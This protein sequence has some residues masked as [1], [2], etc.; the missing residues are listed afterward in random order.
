[1]L[2]AQPS[3]F[4][5]E[6]MASNQQFLLD[7]D[8]DDSDWIELYNATAQSINVLG[9]TLSDKADALNRWALPDTS[10]EPGGF[11]VVFA[12]G[13]DRRVAGQPLH[14]NFSIAAAGE[15]LFL[16]HNGTLVHSLSAR[17]LEQNQSAGLV[18]DGS[19][20]YLRIAN[21]SPGYTNA[22][23]GVAEL[24]TFSHPGGFYEAGFYLSLQSSHPN[25]QIRYTLNGDQPTAQSARYS[26]PLL[27]NETARNP[28]QLQQ[29]QLGYSPQFAPDSALRCILLRAALFDSSGARMSRPFTQTYLMGTLGNQHQLPV[30]S[31]SADSLAL[32]SRDSGILVPGIHFE[33]NGAS[34]NYF[35]SGREWERW[36]NVEYIENGN[37]LV[38]HQ[39]GLRVHGNSTRTIQ[40]KGLR[41]YA[42]SSYGPSKFNHTFFPEKN[43][44]RFDQLALKP[45]R[46]AWNQAGILDQ[47]TN[48][49]AQQ[50]NFEAPG[51][52]AVVLYLN[53]AYWGIYY[54]QER[55]DDHFISEN[56]PGL[57]SDS[58][59]VVERWW[60]EGS[61]GL[62]ADFL[63]LINFVSAHDLTDAAHYQTVANWID[64]DNFIDYQLF[65][66]YIANR[67]WPDNNIK[68]WREIRPGGK[69]RWIF[70]D[71]DGAMKVV[72]HKSLTNA[73]SIASEG[74]AN[75]RSTALFRALI[76]NPDF[77]QAFLARADVLLTQHFTAAKGYALTN[78]VAEEV[79]TE[80]SNNIDRFGWPNSMQSW[81]E[82][83]EN[84]L[85]FAAKRP[86]NLANQF[87][88]VFGH[89]VPLNYDCRVPEV[90]V[91][92]TRLFPNPNQGAFA[93]EF[94]AE[95]AGR[96][97][98]EI[99][100]LSGRALYSAF[101]FAQPGSNAIT[102]D[103][104]LEHGI[105]LL[106][107]STHYHSSSQKLVINK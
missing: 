62:S 103:V 47:W 75:Q 15:A 36:C 35:Q 32:F 95:A 98:I 58:V 6:F 78:R 60:G 38:N 79:L 25:F 57:A 49:A 94:E 31:I 86:C 92:I 63:A 40:Q 16:A 52:K 89:Q 23:A 19:T 76:R 8:G 72:N 12:S 91:L 34:G 96:C 70:H 51:S 42:R 106:Q 22:G 13:K 21:P 14:T 55:I 30:L 48:Q 74:A 101:V 80:V 61:K 69:W 39:A 54:L 59:E 100:D 102:L 64:I 97:K 24:V 107:L 83:V 26:S 33:N 17:E 53:G 43:I 50:L 90:P 29:I 88:S 44:D 66:I 85:D 9:Y 82:E 46:A 45:F 4:I 68:C 67:D 11:L 28:A 77:R 84:T 56:F 18:P 87:A 7:E 81:F 20:N 37:S 41:L 104:S 1:M 73:M 2:Q 105:Y 99:Y 10:L 27:L 5:N 71:G 93:V 65:Q 3:V